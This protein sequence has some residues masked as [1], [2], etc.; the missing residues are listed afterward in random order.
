MDGFWIRRYR[1]E[2]DRVIRRLRQLGYTRLGIKRIIAGERAWPVY[3]KC[4]TCKELDAEG[5]PDGPGGLR[6]AQRF[7]WSQPAWVRNY[8]KARDG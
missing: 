3:C 2:P 1:R 4:K 5:P 8:L 7:F 6:H